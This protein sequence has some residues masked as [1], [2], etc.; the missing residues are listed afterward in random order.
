MRVTVVFGSDLG[1]TRAIAAKIAY[2]CGGDFLDIK[3]AKA[4][5]LESCDMLILGCPTYGIGELQCDW[6]EN[7]SLLQQVNLQ[8][9]PVALFGTGDQVGFSDSFADA[10][11][12]LYD[13]VQKK[14]AQIVG[15][16]EAF[17]YEFTESKKHSAMASLLA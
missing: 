14:G 13:E 9:K 4:S 16:T 15:F 8:D 1:S 2:Q 3:K 5:D 11:G 17:D 10:I 6:E 12:T 7:L